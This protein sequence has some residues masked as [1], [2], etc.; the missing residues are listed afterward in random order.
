MHVKFC[1]SQMNC[2]IKWFS[3][4][5]SNKSNNSNKFSSV[6]YMCFSEFGT[7]QKILEFLKSLGFEDFDNVHPDGCKV[8]KITRGDFSYQNQKDEE[9]VTKA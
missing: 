3:N 9:T 2:L 4:T 7:Q 6:E 5:N 8:R 1:T